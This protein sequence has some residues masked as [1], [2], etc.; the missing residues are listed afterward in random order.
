MIKQTKFIFLFLLISCSGFV[1]QIE[2]D[3]LTQKRELFFGNKKDVYCKQSVK[4]EL[5]NAN[6][7]SPRLLL[8]VY[9]GKS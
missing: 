2:S 4:L 9:T 5:I 6:R 1:N 8:R 3:I 7:P